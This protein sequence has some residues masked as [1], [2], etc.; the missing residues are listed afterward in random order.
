MVCL[1]VI[2]FDFCLFFIRYCYKSFKFFLFKSFWLFSF[3]IL[4]NDSCFFGLLIEIEF[5]LLFCGIII[6]VLSF[7]I[8]IFEICEIVF[9]L[10]CV[11]MIVF[12]FNVVKNLSI[13]FLLLCVESLYFLIL[14][15]ILYFLLFSL[16]FFLFFGSL[17]SLRS[18]FLGV[19]LFWYFVIVIRVFWF[20][21]IFLV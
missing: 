9:L 13:L 16:I 2:W 11:K 3:L 17:V 4:K 12:G 1:V 6:F 19:F 8:V 10:L 15:F 14:Y 18:F 7:F 20:C 5:I 21:I